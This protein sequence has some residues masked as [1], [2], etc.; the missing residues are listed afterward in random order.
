MEVAR[1]LAA[2]AQGSSG[3]AMHAAAQLRRCARLNSLVPS[4]STL[5]TCGM[6]VS[7]PFLLQ[8]TPSSSSQLRCAGQ[9]CW[10]HAALPQCE[11]PS[12]TVLTKRAGSHALD[13][14]GMLIWYCHTGRT[15]YPGCGHPHVQLQHL[16]IV[17][18][19]LA[20][21]TD[22]GGVPSACG[23]RRRRGHPPGGDQRQDGA[24][25][26]AAQ[27]A[28]R[29]GAQVRAGLVKAEVHRTAASRGC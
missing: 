20:L 5:P 22:S 2:A 27:A 21:M 1:T 28:A 26:Q 16:Y 12:G 4:G 14:S 19:W 24:A 18:L 25:G 9:A 10:Y 15:G 29:H 8:T 11:P 23:R 13:A 6:A 17:F 7:L 3:A